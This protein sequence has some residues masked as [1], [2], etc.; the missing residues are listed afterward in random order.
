MILPLS[1]TRGAR[2]FGKKFEEGY[3]RGAEQATASETATRGYHPTP[4]GPP[5]GVALFPAKPA[6]F[7][8]HP[9]NSS[10]S[11][12]SP[13][14]AARLRRHC[15]PHPHA[16]L[17]S[18]PPAHAVSTPPPAARS[19]LEPP[20]HTTTPRRGDDLSPASPA[21]GPPRP[22]WH[23]LACFGMFWGT[24]P[25][26]TPARTTAHD[27]HKANYCNILRQNRTCDSG[28]HPLPGDCHPPAKPHR[29]LNLNHCSIKSYD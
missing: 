20:V 15:G 27:L 17:V 23:V 1:C 5:P 21:H 3:V 9:A 18:P 2:H 4:R 19:G 6:G 16:L 26:T 8:P 13:A 24:S 29:C 14:A 10:E 7:R 11:R 28:R 25:A 22:K 12:T